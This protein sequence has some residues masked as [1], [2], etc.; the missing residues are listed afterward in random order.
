MVTLI[1]GDLIE[2]AKKGEFDYIIHGCNCMNVMGAGIALQIAN[3]FPEAL[4]ADEAK[5]TDAVEEID[6]LGNY[7]TAIIRRSAPDDIIVFTV[8]NLYTQH[9][10]GPNFLLPAF[11]TGLTKLATVIPKQA[12]IGMPYIGAGIGGGNWEKI[13]EEVRIIFA[14]HDCT[15]VK[16]IPKQITKV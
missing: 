8:I 15:I 1:D 11:V 6:L 7:S 2:L 5:W 3:N 9:K 10:P 12:R 13:Q 14:N 4:R 16:Y